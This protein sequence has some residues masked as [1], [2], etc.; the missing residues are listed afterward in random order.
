M[1]RPKDAPTS[2][3]VIPASGS[4]PARIDHSPATSCLECGSHVRLAC[5]IAGSNT[6]YLECHRLTAAQR[7]TAATPRPKSRL[8]SIG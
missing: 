7:V 6:G 4:A 5:P 2:A 3:P 8:S 1:P